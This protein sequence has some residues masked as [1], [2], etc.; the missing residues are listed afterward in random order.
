MEEKTMPVLFTGHGSPMN[1][2]GNNK[3]RTGWQEMGKRLGK[4]KVI[5]AVS[6]HWSTKGVCVRRSET[7]PQIFDM[8]G[9][10]KELYQIHYEPAGSIEMADAVLQA[11]PNAAINNEWGIDHG[12]WS[13]L[14]NMYP[15]ADVPVVMVS[16][17][18]A[19]DADE[20]FAAGRKLAQLRSQGALILASGNIVHNL[21]MV[22]WD[23]EG[24]YPWADAFDNTIKQAVTMHDFDTPVHY[25][26][27]PDAAKAVPT[28]EHYNPFLT[29]LGAVSQS[30]TVSVWNDYREL[31][32]MS[33]TSYLF[34]KA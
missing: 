6:S 11:L 7:N 19:A 12:I 28:T 2:I 24:G 8:Y 15:E 13:V 18:A 31:G 1:A 5:I 22:D 4:P 16:T 32:S 20:Q 14:S 34:D 23:N 33:M 10:P 21:G 3:A 29:A 27:I 26:T 17:N 25:T 9:F 30:D